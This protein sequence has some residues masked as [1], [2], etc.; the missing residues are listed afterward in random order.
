MVEKRGYF[1]VFRWMIAK[2]YYTSSNTH[3]EI[4]ME[5]SASFGNVSRRS[6]LYRHEFL[7]ELFMC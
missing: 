6:R 7:G 1:S 4:G 5:F 3:V 2:A